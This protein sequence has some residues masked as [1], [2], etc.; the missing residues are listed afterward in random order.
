VPDIVCIRVCWDR[1]EVPFYAD[2]FHVVRVSPETAWPLGRR[3]AALAGA[4]R[5]L[6]TPQAAGMLTLDGD[7]V[8]DPADYEAMFSALAADPAAVHVAP[9]RLWPVSTHADSWV[10]GHGRGV[11]SQEDTD[12]PDLFT[13]GFTYLPRA[14]IGACIKAGMTR[15]TYPNVDRKVCDQAR[16]LGIPARVVRGASPKHLHY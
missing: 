11:F 16:T 8:I 2:G 6:A 5:Q 15:W 14:L 1:T 13:F 10:W 4:W 3:G 7:V 9:L 12:D